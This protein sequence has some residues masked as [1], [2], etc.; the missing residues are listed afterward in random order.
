MSKAL[1]LQLKETLP[2]NGQPYFGAFEIETLKRGNG[3]GII[4]LSFVLLEATSL[5]IHGGMFYSDSTAS[6]PIGSK[7][8]CALGQNS[9]Y[10][11]VFENGKI[12]FMGADK[13]ERL[14]NIGSIRLV[15]SVGVFDAN[16]PQTRIN[17]SRLPKQI[18]HYETN[19]DLTISYGDVK[20]F[21]D[22]PLLRFLMLRGTETNPCEVTGTFENFSSQVLDTVILGRMSKQ[23]TFNISSV[24]PKILNASGTNASDNVRFIGD[25]SSFAERATSVDIPDF[26][27]GITGSLA[28]ISGNMSL[29]TLVIYK[30]TNIT[31]SLNSIPASIQNLNLSDAPNITYTGGR[32][33]A[34]GYRILYLQAAPL[35]SSIIDTILIELSV[36]TWDNSGASKLI[37]LKGTRT[38]ASDSAIQTLVNKGVVITFK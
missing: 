19:G 12:I 26:F 2:Y 27:S 20:A 6:T 31:G 16:H 9:I 28:S 36:V 4:K 21:Q 30:N 33:W 7:A 32:T 24:K 15:E 13:I 34:N 22:M 38:S 35:S 10:V 37:T 29:T 5:I 8:Y 18:V 23:P 17:V 25:I 11:K 3:S 14:G 1:V